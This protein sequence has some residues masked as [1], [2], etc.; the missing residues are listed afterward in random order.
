M[1]IQANFTPTIRFILW[2]IFTIFAITTI[3]GVLCLFEVLKLELSKGQITILLSFSPIL[4]VFAILL[5]TIHYY[6]DN[7]YLRLKIGFV[8]I[9]GGRVV[10]DNIVNIVLREH[11]MY[12]SYMCNQLDPIISQIS[13]EEKHYKKLVDYLLSKNNQIVLF[14]DE[15][16]TTNS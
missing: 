7:K 8:D 4:S 2:I 6:V 9:L 10:I 3:I 14:E 13:I 5:A 11:K 12:I 16:E 15:N 1:K